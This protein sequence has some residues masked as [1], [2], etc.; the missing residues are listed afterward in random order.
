MHPPEFFVIWTSDRVYEM[1]TGSMRSVLAKDA[2]KDSLVGSEVRKFWGIKVQPTDNCCKIILH[3]QS[4]ISVTKLSI[5]C[6]VR[7]DSR[8]VSCDEASLFKIFVKVP[9]DIKSTVYK[10]QS[11]ITYSSQVIKSHNIQLTC[12][13]VT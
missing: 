9:K 4:Q 11:Y 13:K 5:S 10:S 7:T 8:T 2:V 3:N 1:L 12:H 6:L